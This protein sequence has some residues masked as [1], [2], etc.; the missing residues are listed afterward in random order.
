MKE[1]DFS[2]YKQLKTPEEWIDKALKIPNKKKAPL[3]FL[4]PAVIGA[5]AALVIT[6][7]VV[8]T[9]RYQFGAKPP[10]APESLTAPPSVTVAAEESVGTTGIAAATAAEGGTAP[11]CTG[12]AAATAP[13]GET[14][15][16]GLPASVQTVPK[17]TAAPYTGASAA[18]ST[19]AS[20]ASDPQPL[21]QAAPTQQTTAPVTEQATEPVTEVQPATEDKPAVEVPDGVYC[22]T[23]TL[24]CP[25]NSPFYQDGTVHVRIIPMTEEGLPYTFPTALTMVSDG[26][27][28]EKAEK[29]AVLDPLRVGVELAGDYYI[30]E[31]TDSRGNRQE[32]YAALFEDS[33]FIFYI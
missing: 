29:T 1:S 10:V 22:G 16:S 13:E 5:A 9:L 12:T 24:M 28:A 31:V 23:L 18:E 6:A 3:F 2:Q 21:T 15:A 32:F 20:G 19:A 30:V 33:S 7:A 27:S 26:W 25:A 11:V 14:V 8:L 4:R 17:P